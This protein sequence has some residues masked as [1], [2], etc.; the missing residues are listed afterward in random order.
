MLGCLLAAN[1]KQSSRIFHSGD[2]RK[3][4]GKVRETVHEVISVMKKKEA[5]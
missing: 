1:S 4:R 2:E 3:T 5:P